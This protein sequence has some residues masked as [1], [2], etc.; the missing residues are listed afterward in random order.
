M[1]IKS[2]NNTIL[3]CCFYRSK[4]DQ[5]L[6]ACSPGLAFADPALHLGLLVVVLVVGVV[7]PACSGRYHGSGLACGVVGWVLCLAKGGSGVQVSS[8]Q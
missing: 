3:W 1:K 8:F 6:A 2:K 5:V 4:S 7:P